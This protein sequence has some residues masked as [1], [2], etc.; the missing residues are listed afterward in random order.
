[1]VK[2]TKQMIRRGLEDDNAD[3]TDDKKRNGG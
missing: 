1:M 2:T 3:K